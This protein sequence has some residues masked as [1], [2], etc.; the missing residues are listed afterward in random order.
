MPKT[1]MILGTASNVGK[2]TVTNILCRYF[3]KKGYK[4]APFKSQNISDIAFT[5]K[6][7]RAMSLA[8]SLQATACNIEPDCRMNPVLI[9]PSYNKEKNIFE[10]EIILNGLPYK[11]IDGYSQKDIKNMLLDEI[12]KSYDSLA[13]EYDVIII[14]GAGSCAE[15]NLVDND[16]TNIA[17]AKMA[18]AP[19]LLVSD[20]DR[21]GVFAS[22]Y[23]SYM[24]QKEED[25]KYIKG[26][27]INKF[28]GNIS[29][30]IND[31]KMLEDLINIPSVAVLP[32]TDVDIEPEDV[33]SANDMKGKTNFTNDFDGLLEKL[34]NYI[35][36]DLIEKIMEAG[37]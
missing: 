14:E 34:E 6:D 13:K 3:Y 8:Q 1:I 31:I 24:L 27:I 5:T 22:L 35:D 26:T 32:Y 20:I 30:F 18:N 11:K 17:I 25:K 19:C 29:S 16:I 23:G 12:K 37:V 10:S 2:S 4:V 28:S 33:L 36:F 7:G 9:K 21:G 15:I